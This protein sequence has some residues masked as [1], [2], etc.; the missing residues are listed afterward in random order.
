MAEAAM[1]VLLQ[2]GEVMKRAGRYLARLWSENRGIS[3]VE[4]ALL[5]S[6]IAG[7]VAFGATFLGDAVSNEIQ[8]TA[9]CL[10]SDDPGGTGGGSGGSKG[11]SGGAPPAGGCLSE[12]EMDPGFTVARSDGASA[13]GYQTPV[14]QTLSRRT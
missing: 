12:L 9:D 4:Y 6:F 14:V 5:L 7:G 8:D 2:T 13:S 3:S 1:V 11:G 10:V